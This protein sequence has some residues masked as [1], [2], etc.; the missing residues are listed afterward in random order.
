VLLL[1][2]SR[3]AKLFCVRMAL[4]RRGRVHRRICIIDVSTAFL[5][6]D[7]YPDGMVKYVSFKHPLTKKWI[8]FKQS[9]PIYG[10]ASAPVRWENT[11][12][13]WLI[14]QG[15]V[16]GEFERLRALF[17]VRMPDR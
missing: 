16:R 6:S 14:E 13:P 11:I 1:I 12:T 3:M 5:Q 15:F 17:M 2:N 8:Y 4:F 9:G 7:P 10:E